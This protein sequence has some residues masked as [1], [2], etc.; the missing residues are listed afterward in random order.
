[1]AKSRR[2]L[3]LAGARLMGAEGHQPQQCS[4]FKPVRLFEAANNIKLLLVFDTAALR[5]IR[6]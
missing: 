5:E 3:D 4:Q 6:I 1:M 2:C